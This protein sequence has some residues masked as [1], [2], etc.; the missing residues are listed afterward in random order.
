LRLRLRGGD[1][2]GLDL[3][4][5]LGELELGLAQ[6]VNR[7]Q[8]RPRRGVRMDVAA[9]QPRHF[10]LGGRFG[11]L[12]PARPEAA[13]PAQHQ[14]GDAERHQRAA[15]AEDDPRLE[16]ERRLGGGQDRGKAAGADE[17]REQIGGRGEGDEGDGEPRQRRDRHVE[18]IGALERSEGP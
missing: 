9:A 7:E 13:E 10:E 15:R 17:I 18:R 8:G 2:L 1:R 5:D 14:H 11:F 3:D 16:A 12:R 6:F 4:L